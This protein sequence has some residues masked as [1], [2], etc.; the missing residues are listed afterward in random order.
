MVDSPLLPSEQPSGAGSTQRSAGCCGRRELSARFWLA[1]LTMTWASFSFGMLFGSLSPVLGA[2]D[3]CA[4]GAGGAPP[5][6]PGCF[7]CDLS[8]STATQSWWIL[9]GPLGTVALG[10][11]GG[12]GLD[13]WGHRAMLLVGGLVYVAGWACF[14]LTPG[15]SGLWGRQRGADDLRTDALLLIFAGRML[16]WSGFAFM[17]GVPG[18]YLAEVSPPRLRGAAGASCAIA[19]MIGTLAEFGLGAVLLQWRQLYLA[20]GLAFLPVPLLALC[21]PPSPRWLQGRL[22]RRN[23]LLYREQGRHPTPLQRTEQVETIRLAVRRLYA[24]EESRDAVVEGVVAEITGGGAA[25]ESEREK[26][27]EPSGGESW[28]KVWELRLP[29]CMCGVLAVVMQLCPGGTAA[30]QFSGPILDGFAAEQRNLIALVCNAAALPGCLLA[31]MLTDRVGRLRLLLASAV[32]QAAASLCLGFFFFVK[33]RDP[34]WWHGAR[35]GSGAPESGSGADGT[36]GAAQLEWLAFLSLAGAQFTYTLGWGSVTGVL[37]SELMPGAV[38]GLGLAVA[39][40]AGGIANSAV[41]TFF[42]PL[43]EAVGLDTIFA[44]MGG[45]ILV[46][47]ILVSIWVPETAGQGLEH[48]ERLIRSRSARSRDDGYSSIKPQEEG[49]GGEPRGG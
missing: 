8:L 46:V 26:E 45:N 9:V 13:R 37:M 28:E 17:A 36:D 25:Q 15:A 22:T 31:L 49:E 6:C 20:N 23:Q 34:S 10:P 24:A 42:I 21:L 11:V 7:N 29:V 30:V 32:G 18:I 39:Q 3:A 27:A 33:T 35:D 48:I 41:S 12:A 14:A 5:T 19:I 38:R 44:A 2:P 40:S 43:S 47:T 16:T 4:A 1:A